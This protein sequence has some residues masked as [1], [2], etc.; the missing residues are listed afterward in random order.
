MAQQVTDMSEISKLG[1]FPNLSVKWKIRYF[2][3]ILYS[4]S[5]EQFPPAASMSDFNV[6]YSGKGKIV[7]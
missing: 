5:G 1:A 7:R 6:L 4:K 3:F 2:L